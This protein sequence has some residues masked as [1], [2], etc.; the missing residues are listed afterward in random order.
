VAFLDN[1]NVS[2]EQRM[3]VFRDNNVTP[4][5]SLGGSQ[6]QARPQTRQV[7]RGVARVAFK[8]I[9]WTQG[10]TPELYRRIRNTTAPEL[11][12]PVRERP[13]SI[14][15]NPAP[16]VTNTVVSDFQPTTSTNP[17]SYNDIFGVRDA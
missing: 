11:R 6:A 14:T 1:P 2:D 15:T 16:T 7:A 9:N 17:E 10:M 8:V 5:A 13:V 12:R 3:V 4:P